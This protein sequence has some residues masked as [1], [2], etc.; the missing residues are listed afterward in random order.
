MRT[1]GIRD[2][3][4]LSEHVQYNTEIQEAKVVVLPGLNGLILKKGFNFPH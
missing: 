3:R 4:L 1:E 2:P